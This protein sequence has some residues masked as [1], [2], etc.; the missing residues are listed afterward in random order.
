MTTQTVPLVTLNNGVEMPALGL[1]VLLLV[2]PDTIP[3][4]TIPGGHPMPAMGQMGS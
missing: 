1:G 3:G 2:S 4:L